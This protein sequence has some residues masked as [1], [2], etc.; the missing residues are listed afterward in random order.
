MYGLP[1]GFD[2]SRFVGRT[3]EQVSFSENT[4]HLAFDEDVGITISSSFSHSTGRGVFRSARVMSVPVSDSRLMQL[5]GASVESAESTDEGTLT[6]RFTNGHVFE[7][8]DDSPM[9][10]SYHLTFGDEEIHI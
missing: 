3:V 4:V 2:A 8:Y 6:L 10:E 9:Y 1:P 5:A 7:C